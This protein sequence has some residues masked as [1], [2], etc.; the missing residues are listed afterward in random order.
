MNSCK[1]GVSNYYGYEVYY[2]RFYG[3]EKVRQ[4]LEAFCEKGKSPAKVVGI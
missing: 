1:V 2:T 4:Q 3:G